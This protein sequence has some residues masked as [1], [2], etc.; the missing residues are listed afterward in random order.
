MMNMWKWL[1]WQGNP[2]PLNT[3]ENITLKVF[4]SNDITFVGKKIAAWNDKSYTD[5]LKYT[6]FETKEKKY[7]I[8]SGVCVEGYAS[9]WKAT[10]A[11]DEADLVSKIKASLGNSDAFRDSV[12]KDLANQLYDYGLKAFSEF[13]PVRV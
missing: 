10:I 6:V 4:G 7:I 12:K 11:E 5:G 13:L 1:S 9:D 3:F 2:I 8:H